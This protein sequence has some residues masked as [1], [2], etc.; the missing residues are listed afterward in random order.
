MALEAVP[1]SITREHRFLT[2]QEPQAPDATVVDGNG[3]SYHLVSSDVPVLDPAYRP[4]S[5]FY[6]RSITMDIVPEGINNLED[7]FPRQMHIAD[8]QFS[9]NIG[10]AQDP[11]D[12]VEVYEAF[13]GQVDCFYT[14]DG[15]PDNDVVRLPKQMDFEV[16]SDAGQDA[17]EV[18]ALALLDVRYELTS[19]NALGLPVSY[20]A[21]MTFRGSESWLQLHHYI[22]TAYYEGYVQ[23]SVTQYLTVS[24]YE[25]DKVPSP[26]ATLT[27]VPAPTT[28]AVVDS[29]VVQQPSQLLS[30]E[31]AWAT[32]TII[33]VLALAW[34]LA[35][36][37]FWRKNAALVQQADGKGK[38][39]L[40]RQ[41]SVTSGE[42]AFRI[43]D[44]L[45]LYGQNSYSI[46]LKP[47][48]AS[49]QG[50]LVAMWRGSVIARAELRPSINVSIAGVDSPEMLAVV[51]EKLLGL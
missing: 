41:I 47:R 34:L 48:L 4:V 17:T 22:V 27:E 14:L 39:L 6:S 35:W 21:H 33:V 43:P 19:T 40:R 20:S 28:P 24:H 49:Q 46:E 36:L 15:L 16:R 29:Q 45:E 25:L 5:G 32:A 30:P 1:A 11:Y 50:M 10:L 8:G 31:L 44:G 13:S 23:S 42:A 9:G 3:N 37:L 26:A 12:K 7:Y 38:V 18:K 2:G 51:T